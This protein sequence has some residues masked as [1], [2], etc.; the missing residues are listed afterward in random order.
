MRTT[1][2]DREPATRFNRFSIKKRR[3]IW[4]LLALLTVTSSL[5]ATSTIGNLPSYTVMNALARPSE[6]D[7]ENSGV[8][9]FA[10]EIQVTQSS[11]YQSLFLDSDIYGRAQNNL[12][13]IRIVNASGKFM[14]YYLDTGEY[15]E[16]GLDREYRLEEVRRAVGA[17]TTKF[18]FRVIP[19]AQN[20]DVRGSRLTF[21]L[22]KTSFLKNV[23]IEGSYDGK[24]WEAVTQSELY[25]TSEGAYRNTIELNSPVT[26]S[27]Y[28][29][30]APVGNDSFDLTAGKL[31]DVATAVSGEAFL[32]TEEIPFNV[33]S[34]DSMSEVVL[35]NADKLK[36]DRIKLDA[37]A[38]DGA[39]GFS[40]MFYVN[41]EKGIGANTRIL[42]PSRLNRL[43]LSGSKIDDT[44]IRLA[45]PIDNE[46][47]IVVIDNGGNSPLNIQSVKVSYRVD[48]L[49]F[50]DTG[51]GPYRIVYG[52]ENQQMPDYDI[53]AF[54]TEIEQSKPSKATLGKEYAMQF[55]P[56]PPEE[57]SDA[58]VSGQD[59][60]KIGAS[61]SLQI[62]FNI[63]LI[64]VALILIVVVGRKLRKK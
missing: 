38:S 61:D 41:R 1:N 48:R 40:R 20:E 6:N 30:T 42:S 32:R 23:Q 21:E 44:E 9:T 36:I 17:N 10:K 12:G 28:R 47:P 15:G 31:I 63:V 33:E 52:A 11:Q 55:V 3:I 58:D 60:P 27:Y 18:D 13:D 56:P 39:S 57:D 22:P 62:L 37:T 16:R 26:Y 43:Q 50:E 19:S 34:A 2:N 24:R 59:K 49:V 54:R 51:S 25:S 64:A 8:W 7:D 45:E 14:P 35:Y 46:K 5:P 4:S 29:V 53:Y